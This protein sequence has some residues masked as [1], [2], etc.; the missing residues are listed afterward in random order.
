MNHLRVLIVDDEPLVRQGIRHGLSA[1]DGIEMI[2]ECG[3]GVEAAA[4]ILSQRPDLVL[5]DVQLQDCTGLDVVAQIG[6]Q[7]M[8]PVI[9]I[10]AYDEYAVKAFELNAVDY[11]LKPFDD[12]RLSSSIR[13]AQ[14]RI[15]A[16]KQN[17]LGEQL[18]AL[19]DLPRKR[20]PERI[21]VKNGERFDIVA[22]ETIDWIESANNYVQLHCGPRQYTLGETLTSLGNRLDPARFVR[23]HRGRIINVSRLSAVHAMLGGTYEIELRSGERISSGRQYKNAIQAIIKNHP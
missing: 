21:V 9:F 6:P 12:E 13:R 20:W 2:G 17:F 10:T 16:R 23:I 1:V 3:S 19:L 7:N 18:Q 15:T 11:V 14:E 5:L 8:P 4:A 22:T